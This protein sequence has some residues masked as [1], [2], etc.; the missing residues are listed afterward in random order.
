[1]KYYLLLKG[2]GGGCDASPIGGH[3]ACNRR[4]TYIE[5]E[6]DDD[7]LKLAADKVIEIGRENIEKMF[8]IKV[9]NALTDQ[10]KQMMEQAEIAEEQA[11]EKQ[12]REDEE[13]KER[14]EYER[15]SKKFKDEP[16]DD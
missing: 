14:A 3:L 16:A 9:G 11:E 7:A 8:F 1:M 2:E 10:L 13:A 5:A 6:S 4:F 15:L 12:L